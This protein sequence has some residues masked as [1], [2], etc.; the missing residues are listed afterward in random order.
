[1]MERKK[2]PQK[3]KEKEN[4]EKKTM[5]RKDKSGIFLKNDQVS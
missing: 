3:R 5:K 1:M 2:N 4:D